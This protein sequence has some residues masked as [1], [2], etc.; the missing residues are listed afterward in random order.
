VLDDSGARVI[1][2]LDHLRPELPASKAAILSLNSFGRERCATRPRLRGTP[3]NL[4]Y[5]AERVQPRLSGVMRN[6]HG[7]TETTIWSSTSVVRAGEPITIGRPL[8]NTTIH[9][10]DR[11]LQ[12]LPIGAGVTVDAPSRSHGLTS[13]EAPSNHA[14]RQSQDRAEMRRQAAQRMASLRMQSARSR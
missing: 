4:A 2:T 8:A 10:V 3:A 9:I 7:P 5:L 6:M 1:L 12:A 13:Q 14:V 11:H